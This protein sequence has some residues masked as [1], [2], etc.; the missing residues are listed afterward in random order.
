MR[1]IP[2]EP[3]DRAVLERSDALVVARAAFRWS[4]L[5]TWSNVLQVFGTG[6][7]AVGRLGGRLLI[8]SR[9]CAS[10]NRGGLTVFLD[11]EN[12]LVIRDG[13]TLLVCRADRPQA[14]RRV[15]GRL[16]GRWARH[17]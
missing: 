14:V 15:P 3:I 9:D 2:S 8:R 11:V 16:R 12:L 5:G 10:V 1:R 13:D 6:R 17:A 4:D 7:G